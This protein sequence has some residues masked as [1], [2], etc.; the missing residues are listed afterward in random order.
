VKKTFETNVDGVFIAGEL[1]G[2]GLI[3]NAV[4]QGKQAIDNIA[5]RKKSTDQSVLD[6]VIVGAGPAGLAAS[7]QAEK[8]GLRYVCVEQDEVGGTIL[9]YPRQKLVMTQ[10]M[11]IPLYGK[12]SKREILK[13]ELLELW[14]E[15]ITK[16]GI[17]INT[18]ERLESIV[19]PNGYFEIQTT[20]V[21]YAT[22]Q[23]L[24]AI[25]RRRLHLQ[26]RDNN[27]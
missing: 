4:T 14:H 24:L 8:A 3:R 1:G 9:S 21:Q 11:E 6:V 19:R 2:M 16:T 23:V 25:G 17:G 22:R 26:A 12:Y 13:E 18:N 5:A 10:P 20:R 27:E 15:V 7:L